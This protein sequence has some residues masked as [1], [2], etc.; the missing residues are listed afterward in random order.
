MDGAFRSAN[1]DEC[2]LTLAGGALATMNFPYRSQ[3]QL[4]LD[5]K[6]FFTGYVPDGQT[7]D[8]SGQKNE[9]RLQVLGPWWFLENLVFMSTVKVIDRYDGTTPIFKD[10]EVTHF[11][12]NVTYVPTVTATSILSLPTILNTQD[13]LAAILDYAISQGAAIQYTKAELMAVKILPR[14]VMNITCADA[15][16]RQMEEVDAVCWFDHSQNPPKFN[17]KRRSELPSVVRAL[18]NSY[19]ALGFK[20]KQRME[21]KVPFVRIDFEQINSVDGQ[22]YL[23]I[24]PDL[25][26]TPQPADRLKALIVSVPVR[27]SSATTVSQYIKTE[28][29][30]VTSVDFWKNRKPEMNGDLNPNAATEFAGLQLIGGTAQRS[31]SLPNLIVDGSWASWM[32]GKCEADNLMVQATYE[33]QASGKLTGDKIKQHTLRARARVTDLDFPTGN[34]KTFTFYSEAGEDINQ[35]I[36]MAQ[37]IYTDL[38][39]DK[40]EGT[41]PLFF[42]KWDAAVTLGVNLNLTNSRPEHATMNALVQEISWNSK[43]GSLVQS[44]TVG[45][46]K[47][48]SP[49]QLADRLRAKRMAYILPS[50]V[51]TS[52][53]QAISLPQSTV[54]DNTSTAEPQHT[55][56]HVTDGTG[57]VLQ[58]VTN[59]TPVIVLQ[60]FTPAGVRDTTKGS[61]TFDQSKTLGSDNK[62]HDVA[63]REF[64]VNVLV[65]GVCKQRT[66]ILAISDIYQAPDDPA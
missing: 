23:T 41:V 42:G 63:L 8:F 38:V 57:G 56:K 43:P 2:N 33:R 59:G 44:V 54:Q 9:G 60:Q 14:D 49:Q 26:P 4:A 7:N 6:L 51:A 34:T 24:A 61:V 58:Q 47:K 65:N 20:L 52:N 37:T 16:R 1:N 15:I 22:Q 62:P 53:P 17:C 35:F 46:N 28:K 50:P 29:I 48:L 64:K 39:A 30:D 55:Q 31:S 21:D 10:Q 3:V 13:Q 18:G 45:S 32:G 11:K 19:Q 66:A 40:W 25:Y 27:G 12:L 36:G 5:D